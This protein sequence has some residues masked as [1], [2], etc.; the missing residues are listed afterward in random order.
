VSVVLPAMT[1]AQETAWLAMLEVFE[2][3][4]PS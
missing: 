4:D 3:V 2:R 1:Q